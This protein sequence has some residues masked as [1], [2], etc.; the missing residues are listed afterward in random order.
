MLEFEYSVCIVYQVSCNSIPANFITLDDFEK[1]RLKLFFGIS[2]SQCKN[3]INASEV[4]T[5]SV[6]IYIIFV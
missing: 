6:R 4:L 3:I 2:N 5:S 1:T